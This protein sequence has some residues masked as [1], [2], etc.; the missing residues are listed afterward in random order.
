M[1]TITFSVKKCTRYLLVLLL[2]CARPYVAT[3]TGVRSTPSVI[4]A[5][6]AFQPRTGRASHAKHDGN[7]KRPLPRLL[8]E[9]SREVN[10]G[11]TYAK[12]KGHLSTARQNRYRDTLCTVGVNSFVRLRHRLQTPSIQSTHP[13]LPTVGRAR[14]SPPASRRIILS[15]RIILS[16][17]ASKANSPTIQT[18]P[19]K[20]LPISSTAELILLLVFCTL[21]R[22][23]FARDGR[24]RGAAAL[25]SD[26]QP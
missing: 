4:C 23:A 1:A 10:A 17:A 22:D 16:G 12:L 2:S 8:T 25:G 7:P 19:R 6:G 24:H 18:I 21:A 20:M 26:R 11:V 14:P 5:H 9:G 13:A 15:S 3:I